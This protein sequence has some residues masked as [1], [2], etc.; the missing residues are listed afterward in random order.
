MTTTTTTNSKTSKTKK[1]KFNMRE[2]I[3]T[4]LQKFSD[5][6]GEMIVTVA[7]T[8]ITIAFMYQ[9]VH[10]VYAATVPGLYIAG[11]VVQLFIR[12]VHRFDE[13]Y[14]VDE[15]GAEIEQIREQL[16]RIE[17]NV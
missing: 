8:G 14:T 7:V 3:A 13:H 16:N 1:F 10:P 5:I 11:M 9:I 12:I 6:I 17:R 15:L 2:F 4:V